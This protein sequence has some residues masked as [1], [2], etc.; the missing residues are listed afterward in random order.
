MASGGRSELGDMVLDVVKRG[1]VAAGGVGVNV[2]EGGT[3]LRLELEL[4]PP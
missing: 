1:E 2:E 4:P 3:G